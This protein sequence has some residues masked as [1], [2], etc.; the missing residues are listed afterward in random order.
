MKNTLRT[1]LDNRALLTPFIISLLL[2]VALILLC[3]LH[4]RPSELQVP[5][6]YTSFG[7]TNFYTEQWFYQ[8]MFLLFGAVTVGVHAFIGA[9]LYEK[10]GVRFARMFSWLTVIVMTITFFTVIAIFRIADLS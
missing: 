5:V 8:L 2:F 6:R 7:V 3:A 10:K 4:I 9:Q 1:Y